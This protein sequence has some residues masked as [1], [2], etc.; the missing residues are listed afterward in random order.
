MGA[1]VLRLLSSVAAVALSGTATAADLPMPAEP[2]P[3]MA[4]V[5]HNWSGFYVGVSGGFGGGDYTY[6]FDPPD[7][8]ND[9]E[10]WLAGGQGGF[11]QQSGMFVFGGVADI[12]W[13]DIEGDSACPNPIYACD[14][15][16]EW[17]GTARGNAGVAFDRFLIYA[18]GGFAFGGMERESVNTATGT[19]LTQDET[20]IGWT[21]GGGGAFGV[22]NN[23]IVGAEALWV[24]LDEESFDAALLGGGAF[25]QVDLGSEFVIVRGNASFK[26]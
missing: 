7:V 10:G 16:V 20:H 19:T 23:L 12:S 22:T 26:F 14:A 4:P 6:D 8:G 21:A 18:S 1:H 5:I 11:N 3:A 13:A 9:L 24:D 15:S 17:L 2:I 25:S